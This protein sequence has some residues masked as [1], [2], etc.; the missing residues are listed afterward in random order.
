MNSDVKHMGIFNM[1]DLTDF[2]VEIIR[3]PAGICGR[4]G[5]ALS[6]KVQIL[7]PPPVRAYA[8]EREFQMQLY[9]KRIVPPA[10]DNF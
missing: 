8:N 4:A 7:H 3:A 5:A 10:T 1:S 9:S 6:S 2:R